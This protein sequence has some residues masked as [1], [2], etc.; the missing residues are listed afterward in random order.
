L[1]GK[2]G[3]IAI[4]VEGRGAHGYRDI[5]ATNATGQSLVGSRERRSQ[6]CG[7]RSMGGVVRVETSG[8]E[9]EARGNL[10]VGGKAAEVGRFAADLSWVVACTITEPKDVGYIRRSYHHLLPVPLLIDSVN[11]NLTCRKAL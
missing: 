9:T 4:F 1:A 10:V 2:G 7:Q 6:G 3:K 8:G 5:R 11:T